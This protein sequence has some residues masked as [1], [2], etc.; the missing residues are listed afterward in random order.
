MELSFCAKKEQISGTFICS[1][2]FLK[3]F[4]QKDFEIVVE[5]SLNQRY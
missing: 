5:F 2:N 3:K 4:D 1:D